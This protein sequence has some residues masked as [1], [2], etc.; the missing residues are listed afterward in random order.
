MFF[1]GFLFYVDTLIPFE[2]A[3]LPLSILLF[4]NLFCYLNAS[5]TQP[6]L[7][8]T[9][10]KSASFLSRLGAMLFFAFTDKDFGREELWQR[11]LNPSMK[12]CRSSA[13]YR[14]PKC[15]QGGS[16]P[17]AAATTAD[18]GQSEQQSGNPGV[19]ELMWGGKDESFRKSPG[20]ARANTT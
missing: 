2:F 11:G 3:F 17:A 13:G 9:L 10:Y 18:L 7:G 4:Y 20:E 14:E 6:L 1:R 12:A 5:H 15:R 19:E 16:S 8:R